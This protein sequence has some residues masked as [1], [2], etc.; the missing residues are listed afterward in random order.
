M[1][2]LLEPTGSG[3]RYLPYTCRTWIYIFLG[4]EEA[5]FYIFSDT[6]V[7]VIKNTEGLYQ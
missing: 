6:T 2:T 5:I 3:P 7:V 1:K 4:S